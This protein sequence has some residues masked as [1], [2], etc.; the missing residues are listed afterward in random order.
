MEPRSQLMQHRSRLFWPCIVPL[1]A[2]YSRRGR[3]AKTLSFP[4][5]ELLFELCFHF[6]PTPAKLRMQ[7]SKALRLEIE[8]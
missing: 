4:Q 8:I 1:G 2:V 3:Q 5:A 6:F 7:D